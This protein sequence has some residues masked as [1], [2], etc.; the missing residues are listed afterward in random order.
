MCFLNVL[1]LDHNNNTNEIIIGH[2][3]IDCCHLNGS[4]IFGSSN[5][6]EEKF[7][8]QLLLNI[9]FN[10]MRIH[11]DYIFVFVYSFYFTFSLSRN[12]YL[13][14]LYEYNNWSFHWIRTSAVHSLIVDR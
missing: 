3:Q 9:Q 6:L 5:D 2:N 13:F 4:F 12:T 10:A 7:T 11:D 1:L 14:N 8:Q